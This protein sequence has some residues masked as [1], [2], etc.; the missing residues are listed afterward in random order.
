MP[1]PLLAGRSSFHFDT[2]KEGE[3]VDTTPPKAKKTKDEP[4]DDTDKVQAAVDAALSA[5]REKVKKEKEEA[6]RK[7]AEDEAKK[8]GEFEKLADSERQARE[9]AEQAVAAAERRAQQAEV[10]IA[11]RDHLATAHPDYA[12]NAPDIM[13]HVA[14]KLT[15]DS[16]PDDIKKIITDEAKAFVE[17]TPRAVVKGTPPA[18]GRKIEPTDLPPARKLPERR[19]FDHLRT[20]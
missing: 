2:P 11:L 3:V 7:A 13:L 12:S 15:P 10:N 1:F 8:N 4:V 16:K 5:E 9:K 19:A 18:P 14:A 6:A 17:R 20:N